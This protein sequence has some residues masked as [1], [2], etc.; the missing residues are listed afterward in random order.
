[1]SLLRHALATLAYRAGKAVRDLPAEAAE[2][3]AYPGSRS[4]V[5]ILAHM[6]DLLDWAYAMA[7]GAPVWRNSAPL[8][9][10]REVE[11]FFAALGKFDSYLASGAQVHATEERLFQGPVADALTHTGQLAIL[12]RLAG[13]PMRGENYFKAEI[14]VGVV[15]LEQ[16]PPTLEFG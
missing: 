15:G 8:P 14:T 6:G 7:S 9:W 13:H 10:P 2:Y 3:R 16:P 1:M 4:P 5:E 12:R 11:R